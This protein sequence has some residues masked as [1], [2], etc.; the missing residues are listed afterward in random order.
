[1]CNEHPAVGKHSVLMPR[2]SVAGGFNRFHVPPLLKVMTVRMLGFFPTF[3][4]FLRCFML[5][6]RKNNNGQQ[7]CTSTSNTHQHQIHTNNSTHQQQHTPTTAHTNNSTHQQQ[8]TPTTAH[9]NNNTHHHQSTR[10]K[11]VVTC[12]PCRL[13]LCPSY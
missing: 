11:N 6:R 9:T 13:W 8:H 12:R 1:M 10:M 2:L 5:W 3:R 7:Q 4:D